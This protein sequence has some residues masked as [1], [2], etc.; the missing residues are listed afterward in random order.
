MGVGPVGNIV[1]GFLDKKGVGNAD[2]FSQTLA[3]V[4][5]P[6]TG[7]YLYEGEAESAPT[8]PRETVS[9]GFWGLLSFAKENKKLFKSLSSDELWALVSDPDEFWLFYE[10]ALNAQ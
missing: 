6:E 1:Q 2:T 7:A 10:D 9:G 8:H 5:D 3:K 4:Q